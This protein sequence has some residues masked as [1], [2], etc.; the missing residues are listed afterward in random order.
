MERKLNEILELTR[1]NNKMLRKIIGFINTFGRNIT[2]ENAEDFG[3]NV[4]ANLLSNGLE[5][6]RFKL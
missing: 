5:T 6:N 3:R 1:D 2:Q 4:L